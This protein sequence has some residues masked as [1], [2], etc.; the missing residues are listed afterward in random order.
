[1]NEAAA[2]THVTFGVHCGCPSNLHERPGLTGEDGAE[3]GPAGDPPFRGVL[4]QCH[5]QEEHR[6]SA[7]KQEDEVRDQKRTCVTETGT[8]S[9]SCWRALFLAVCDLPPPF[10]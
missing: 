9:E 5:F 3:L 4:A 2:I 10:L 7:A 8:S 6:E 1:M